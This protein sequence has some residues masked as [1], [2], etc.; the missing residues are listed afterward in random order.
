MRDLQTGSKGMSDSRSSKSSLRDLPRS[1]PTFPVDNW[2]LFRFS[3]YL[4]ALWN[5]DVVSLLFS[6]WPVRKSVRNR[7]ADVATPPTPKFR[8]RR[9]GASENSARVYSVVTE[10]SSA[11]TRVLL[12]IGRRSS[13]TLLKDKNERDSTEWLVFCFKKK[14][15]PIA[16]NGVGLLGGHV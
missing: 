5:A 4:V 9:K 6:P 3:T 12:F 8:R 15:L 11:R 16:K 14:K 1:A 7:R 13:S 2:I 10:F